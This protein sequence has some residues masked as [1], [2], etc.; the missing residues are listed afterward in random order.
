MLA[1]LFF[2]AALF[3]GLDFLQLS[4]LGGAARLDRIKRLCR[5]FWRVRLRFGHRFN[6]S[7]SIHIISWCGVWLGFRL[8]H[9]FLQ[10]TDAGGAFLRCQ[11]IF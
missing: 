1:R 6:R 7:G 8:L 10:R 11:T 9:A 3:L 4:K 2:T 5:R